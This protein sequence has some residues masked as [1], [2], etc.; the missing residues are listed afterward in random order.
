MKILLYIFTV[1][2]FYGGS[3]YAQADTVLS[4]DTLKIKKKI[5]L[6]TDAEVVIEFDK[7]KLAPDKV[8]LVFSE[9]FKQYVSIKDAL[10]YND[11]YTAMKN[12][13]KLLDDMKSKTK[14]IDMLNNDDR[15]ILFLKN[16][17]NIR[18]KI[19]SAKFISDQRFLFSEITNGIMFFIKQYGLY[20]KTIYLMQCKVESQTGN[21]LWF[22]DSKDRK[23]PYLGMLNDTT[24]A[25]IKEVWKFR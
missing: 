10:V 16:Y 22:S 12:T 18:N 8:R 11:S 7:S 9:L 4:A 23:N 1:C 15:W 20:D 5:I 24:C 25:K 19:E 14:D 21:S 2:S 17:G 6:S 3:L 13:M